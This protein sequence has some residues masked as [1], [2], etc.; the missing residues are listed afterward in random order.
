M[1]LDRR[2]F[3]AWIC[4]VVATPVAIQGAI[5]RRRAPIAIYDDVKQFWLRHWQ[6]AAK[7]VKHARWI[8]NPEC[9]AQLQALIDHPRR[10]SRYGGIV[11]RGVQQREGRS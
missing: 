10:Q 2:N 7:S 11:A 4:A 3:I 1:I 6:A 5:D 8:V 9:E